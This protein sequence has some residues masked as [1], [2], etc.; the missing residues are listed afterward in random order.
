MYIF[1]FSVFLKDLENCRETPAQVGRCFVA[2]KEEFQ[3]YSIYCQ[4]KPQSEA[5]RRDVGDNNAFFK[6]SPLY[7]YIRSRKLK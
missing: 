1:V 4:N 6:V 5:L 7:V 3:M 2:R